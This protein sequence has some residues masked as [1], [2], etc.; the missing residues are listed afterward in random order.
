VHGNTVYEVGAEIPEKGYDGVASNKTGVTCAAPGADCVLILFADPIRRAFAAVHS[1]W[2]GIIAR[3]P[4]I[5]VKTLK[6]KFG[7][8]S[9]DTLVVMG[10]SICK[11][12]FEF[13]RD[14]VKQFRNINPRCVMNE[15][16]EKN[17]TVDLKLAIRTLLEEEGVLPEHIDDTTS[18]PC[19]FEDPELF[20]SYRRDGRPFASHLGF[21]ALRSKL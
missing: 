14:G 9:K 13:D 1:G 11:T 20:F 3:I 10:P 7:S 16:S 5:A 8:Q 17:P 21:I 18:C 15:N 19:T 4:V 2:R 12:C 6:D